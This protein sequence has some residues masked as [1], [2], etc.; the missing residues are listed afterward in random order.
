[1]PERFGSNSGTSLSRLFCKPDPDVEKPTVSAKVWR[2]LSGCCLSSSCISSQTL[3]RRVR[4]KDPFRRRG[5][6]E[7]AQRGRD[8]GNQREKRTRDRRCCRRGFGERSDRTRN[9]RGYV[10]KRNLGPV[11]SVHQIWGERHAWEP[12]R[13]APRPFKR[14]VGGKGRNLVDG[15]GA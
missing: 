9:V 11:R 1:M 3:R 10:Q 7:R 8:G 14:K 15:S 5:I 6:A 12:G 2:Y 13:G 4:D